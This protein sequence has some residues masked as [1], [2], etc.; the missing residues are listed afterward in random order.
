MKVNSLVILKVA[1]ETIYFSVNWQIEEKSQ[2][3]VPSCLCTLWLRD[4]MVGSVSCGSCNKGPQTAW[5]KIS[6]IYF[7]TVLDTR[8]LK[9]GCWQDQ[10]PLKDAGWGWGVL[11]P[12]LSQLLVVASTPWLVAA[13]LQALLPA[14][15]GL[16]L[17]SVS[18]SLC[19]SLIRSF[20]MGSIWI[21]QEFISKFFT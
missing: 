16:P 20:V 13:S 11:P 5:F 1:K 9:S 3:Y 10:A 8:N 21:I 17:F 19:F 15:H 18:L 6:E 14:S 12:C 2:V 4:F 7:L